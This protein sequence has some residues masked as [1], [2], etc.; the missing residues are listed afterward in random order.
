MRDMLEGSFAGG[1]R[2]TAAVA[3]ARTI[4]GAAA[5]RSGSRARR[6]AGVAGR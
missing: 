5:A 2:V 3:G 1:R 6:G 4:D